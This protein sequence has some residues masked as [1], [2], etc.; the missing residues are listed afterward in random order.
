M[1]TRT[2]LVA[3]VVGLAGLA[4]CSRSPSGSSGG[5]LAVVAAENVW[6][7]IAAQ[8]GGARV[9]V[10]SIIV[11]PNTDPH[12]YEPTPGDAR[13]LAS[14]RYVVYNGIGYDPWAPKL[15][16]ANPVRSRI[17]LNVGNLVGIK[18]GGNPH[19][20]YSPADVS[21]V[22][23]RITAD[24]E[25][26]DPGDAAYFEQRHATV[27]TTGLARYPALITS[28]RRTYAATPVG[29]SESVFAPLAQALG[30]DLITPERS[31]DA[32]SE[33][34]EPS[35]ADKA[36][37]DAQIRTGRIKVYVF[38]S[39]NSTPDVRAQINASKAA[40]I[41][42]TSITEM[43]APASATFQD[44]QAGQLQALEAALAKATSR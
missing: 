25:R 18:P 37:I 36:T 15:L 44:W 17:V 24:Y 39:Q 5:R 41:P 20:W 33:G 13:A 16:S 11:N 3:V 2:C 9:R 19:R 38:N 22:V 1:V 14:A 32:V 29:A 28:I 27:T 7:S 34:G 12:D 40:G 35:S 42:V 26:L 6:G 43:L 21:R 31:L 10:R 8:L 30:L 23:D 4:A